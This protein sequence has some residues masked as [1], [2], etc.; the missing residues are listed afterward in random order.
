MEKTKS[1]LKPCRSC[2]LNGFSKT[3][4]C[5]CGIAFPRATSNDEAEELTLEYMREIDSLPNIDDLRFNGKR[6]TFHSNGRRK[7]GESCQVA[8]I[9]GVAIAKSYERRYNER[10]SEI[11]TLLLLVYE[12]GKEI[13]QL[14]SS[15]AQILEKLD[16]INITLCHMPP[17]KGGPEYLLANERQQNFFGD[18]K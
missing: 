7:Q 13:T 1:D 12:Q 4:C 11:R 15:M 14:K 9:G 6:E 5:H 8:E 3:C 10:E 17:T 16:Q 18:T 2:H